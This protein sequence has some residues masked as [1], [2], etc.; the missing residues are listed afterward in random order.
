MVAHLQVE[1]LVNFVVLCIINNDGVRGVSLA[2]TREG[3]RGYREKLHDG[4]DRWKWPK[5]GGSS[6]L[7]VALPMAASTLKGPR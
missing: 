3:V 2:M 4:E 7:Y 5:D 6:S 1:D